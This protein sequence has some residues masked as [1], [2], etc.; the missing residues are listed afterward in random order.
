MNRREF[1]RN[2]GLTAASIG[3]ASLTNLYGNNAAPLLRVGLIGTGLRG[4]NHLDLLLR[5]KDVELV[6]ICDIEPRMLD[7]AKAR[8]S[9]SGR[10]Q[11]TVYTG[12]GNAW[13][14]MLD[15][16]KLDAVIISTPWE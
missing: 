10:K 9:K 2:T 4:Q 3:L 14:K 13:K 16:N 11:P 1:V 6:A 8:I 15:K 12:D 7:D 5:R